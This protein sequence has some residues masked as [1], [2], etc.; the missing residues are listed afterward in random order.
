[1]RVGIFIL[2]AIVGFAISFITSA[3][4]IDACGARVSSAH[5]SICL[6]RAIQRL[7]QSP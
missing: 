6:D 3:G 7:S 1:M 2:G 4:R 5:V